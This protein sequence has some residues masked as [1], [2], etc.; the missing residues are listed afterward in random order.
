MSVALE[1]WRVSCVQSNLWPLHFCQATTLLSTTRAHKPNKGLR[2]CSILNPTSLQSWYLLFRTVHCIVSFRCVQI[3]PLALWRLAWRN[4]APLAG[5]R[6]PAKAAPSKGQG[7]AS[8]PRTEARTLS[9]RRIN[10]S[11]GNVTATFRA[12]W[13]NK[14][15]SLLS[16]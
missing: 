1:A 12:V 16:T 2:K 13:F 7:P 3:H 11:K 4:G 14:K 6:E 10:L 15:R 8:K 5:A 9:A